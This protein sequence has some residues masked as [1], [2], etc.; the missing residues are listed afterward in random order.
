VLKEVSSHND[1]SY[2]AVILSGT[3]GHRHFRVLAYDGINP[4]RG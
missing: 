3:K 4:E 1:V 2:R